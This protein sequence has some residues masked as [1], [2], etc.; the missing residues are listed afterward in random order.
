MRFGWIG[1]IIYIVWGYSIFCIGE[2]QSG[3]QDMDL[4]IYS[5]SA[6]GPCGPG[7]HFGLVPRDLGVMLGA[8]GGLGK[9][10]CEPIFQTPSKIYSILFSL[11]QINSYIFNIF[12]IKLLSLLLF[13]FPLSL[14]VIDDAVQNQTRPL[15]YLLLPPL[16]HPPLATNTNPNLFS[17]RPSQSPSPATLSQKIQ[18]PHPLSLCYKPK[19]QIKVYFFF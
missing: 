12:K 3:L 2:T 11:G 9:W 18:N 19:F 17:F 8:Y 13:P 14:F 4:P 1:R 7:L 5:R 16:L 10:A 6:F 15:P